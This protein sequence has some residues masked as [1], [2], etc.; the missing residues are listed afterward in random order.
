MQRARLPVVVFCLFLVSSMVVACGGQ[1]LQAEDS[2]SP[3]AT[4][5]LTATTDP[6]MELPPYLV[7]VTPDPSAA[8]GLDLKICAAFEVTDEDMVVRNESV[9]FEIAG[10]EHQRVANVTVQIGDVTERHGCS[11]LRQLLEERDLDSAPPAGPMEVAVRYQ[12]PEGAEHRYSW[13]VNFS[14]SNTPEAPAEVR[15]VREVYRLLQTIDSGKSGKDLT[16]AGYFLDGDVLDVYLL[17][18]AD[19]ETVRAEVETALEGVMPS[20]DIRFARL[21]SPPDSQQLNAWATE[22]RAAVKGT[23][24]IRLHSSS[25]GCCNIWDRVTFVVGT[26]YSAHLIRQALAETSVPQEAVFVELPRQP[27]VEESSNGLH[28]I[29]ATLE[30]GPVVRRGTALQVDVVWTNLGDGTVEYTYSPIVPATLVVFST[31]GEV[32]WASHDGGPIF[33]VGATARLEPG[34]EKRFTQYWDL[35]DEDGFAVPPGD[36]IVQ[37]QTHVG[38]QLDTLPPLVS[39]AHTLRI[40]P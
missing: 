5:S 22:A 35:A 34:E 31:A 24:G 18:N 10:V 27:K 19:L 6:A 13:N 32:V 11:T 21:D 23:D 14:L 17:D 12:D 4:P 28:D 33:A 1:S 38:S 29:D 26:V 7:S 30:F 16:I 15:R 2:E 9:W 39:E 40:E 37:A 8:V 36:Y 25:G 3:T 20:G